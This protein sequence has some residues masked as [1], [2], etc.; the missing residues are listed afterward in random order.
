MIVVVS[1]SCY[2]MDNVKKFVIVFEA[3]GSKLDEVEVVTNMKGEHNIHMRMAL[4]SALCNCMKKILSFDSNS[5]VLLEQENHKKK[6]K[7][8]KEEL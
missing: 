1:R 6:N 8:K 2:N 7:K 5:E 3:I 4:L